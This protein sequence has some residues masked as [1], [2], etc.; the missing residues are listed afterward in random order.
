MKLIRSG[1][2]DVCYN[3]ALEEYVLANFREGSCLMLWINDTALVLGRYQNVYEEINLKEA[4]RTG[5]P[6]V[7]RI[8]GGGTVYHDA[9]NLNYSFFST[10]DPDCYRGYDTFLDPVI[11]SLRT[12]GVPAEKRGVCDLAAYGFKIS[13]SAQTIKDQRILHH[14][15][16]LFDADI[17]RLQGLL[18]PPQGEFCSKS[19]KSV[20]SRVANI[21]EL[22]NCGVDVKTSAEFQE[23]FLNALYPEGIDEYSLNAQEHEEIS[24]LASDKYHTWEWNFGSSPGFTFRK[25]ARFQGRKADVSLAVEQGLV[26][27]LN[28]RWDGSLQEDTAARM[29]AILGKRY[30]YTVFLEQLNDEALAD[31]FF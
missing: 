8:S 27:E 18:K 17:D 7:R 31:C 12:L 29:E 23:A 22:L 11:T 19:I 6:V 25:A 24:A 13:G 1:S 9:G 10:Y 3:L 30:G 26:K 20:R 5:V 14:G 21:K 15:T 2:S 28:F 16:L 4:E